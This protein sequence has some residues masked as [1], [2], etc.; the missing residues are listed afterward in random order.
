M[1][2]EKEKKKRK[3]EDRIVQKVMVLNIQIPSSWNLAYYMC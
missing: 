1:I 2:K 3:E